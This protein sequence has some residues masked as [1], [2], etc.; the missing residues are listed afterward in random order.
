MLAEK[1]RQEEEAAAEA[2]A[3]AARL[4]AEQEAAA[5]AAV[6]EAVAAAKA[7]ALQ[8]DMREVAE[9]K[10]APSSADRSKKKRSHKKRQQEKRQ[11]HASPYRHDV[12][13]EEADEEDGDGKEGDEGEGHLESTLPVDDSKS[14]A[15]SVAAVHPLTDDD[16]PDEQE[17]DQAHP[18]QRQQQTSDVTD[19]HHHQQ[20]QS[21]NDQQQQPMEEVEEEVPDLDAQQF[22]LTMLQGHVFIKHHRGWSGPHKKLVWIDA[23]GANLLLCWGDPKK[24]LTNPEAD[25]CGL[26]AVTDVSVGQQGSE[27]FRKVGKKKD[28]AKYWSLIMADR[29]LDL[30]ADSQAARDFFATQFKRMLSDVALLQRTMVHLY[31]SGVWAP[32]VAA[33]QQGQ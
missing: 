6:A 19:V 5:A 20:Q 2:A 31:T 8:E 22:V 9:E 13:E 30:E 21:D 29:T 28:D 26:G 16:A 1:Q 3:E 24:G 32:Q 15:T 27:V 7:A 11:Q 4:R 12:I 33:E 23:T 17:E 18:Q 10:E 25:C 14:V